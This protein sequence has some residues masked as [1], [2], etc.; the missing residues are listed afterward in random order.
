MWNAEGLVHR[1]SGNFKTDSRDFKAF[2][3]DFGDFRGFNDFN[4]FKRFRPDFK[5][6]RSVV[7]DFSDLKSGF[8][9]FVPQ[10]QGN[11]GRIGSVSGHLP[12]ISR[13]IRTISGVKSQNS[14]VFKP[15]FRVLLSEFT[16]YKDF[17][18]D[19]RGFRSDFRAIAHR[20]SEIFGPLWN[21]TF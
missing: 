18:L 17:R 10:I 21:T 2:R 11:S 4:Y 6:F 13:R 9:V 3:P 8:T 20:I 15:A 19:F 14:K 7:R 12:Q 16:N 1:I 5:E